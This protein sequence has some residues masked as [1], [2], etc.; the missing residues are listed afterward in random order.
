VTMRQL[1]FGGP[2][3]PSGGD[4]QIKEVACPRNHLDCDYAPNVDTLT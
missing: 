2:R 3:D 4:E 1:S